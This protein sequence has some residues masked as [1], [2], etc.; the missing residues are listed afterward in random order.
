[1]NTMSYK[2]FGGISPN[3]EAKM[4]RLGFEVN[5]EGHS[6]TKYGQKSTLLVTCC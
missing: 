1:M 4:N 3:L 6:E 5:V 2:V